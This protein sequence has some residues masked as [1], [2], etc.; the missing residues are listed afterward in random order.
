MYALLLGSIEVSIQL[1]QW[2]AKEWTDNFLD[3]CMQHVLAKEICVHVETYL[4]HTAKLKS[5][6]SYLDLSIFLE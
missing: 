3:A 2:S 6:C 5:H 4:Q 1:S